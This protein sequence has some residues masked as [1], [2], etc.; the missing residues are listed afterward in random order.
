MS[1]KNYELLKEVLF[2]MKQDFKDGMQDMKS[3]IAEINKTLVKNHENWVEHKKRTDINEDHVHELR[4]YIDNMENAIERKI[5]SVVSVVEPHIKKYDNF[6]FTLKVAPFIFLS[7]VIISLIIWSNLNNDS[8]ELF[9]K[10]LKNL[11]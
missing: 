9:F 7:G 10:I 6:I 11:F 4:R 8:R 2:E 1:D 5:E 3:D